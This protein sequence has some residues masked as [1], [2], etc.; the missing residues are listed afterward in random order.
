MSRKT[1]SC[2]FRLYD[3]DISILQWGAD[4]DGCNMTEF[5]RYAL[6]QRWG[7]APIPE[8]IPKSRVILPKLEEEPPKRHGK[9]PKDR[10]IPRPRWR[11]NL[12]D[13]VE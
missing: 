7:D 3:E 11:L 10:S 9:V 12:S 1:T 13:G 8:G 5:L 4:R 6:K 2:T